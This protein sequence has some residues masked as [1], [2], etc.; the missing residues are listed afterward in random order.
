MDLAVGAMRGDGEMLCKRMLLLSVVA[1][2][3]VVHLGL[4]VVII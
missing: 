2:T 1:R 4:L 3:I